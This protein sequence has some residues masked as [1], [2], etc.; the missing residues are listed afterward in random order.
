MY[1]HLFSDSTQSYNDK[2]FI[3]GSPKSDVVQ[4][5]GRILRQKKEKRLFHPLIIDINDNFSIFLNQSKK[6]LSFYNK[7]N[8][9][10][11]YYN[12]DGTSY[13]YIK[14]VKKSKKNTLNLEECLI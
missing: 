6:R 9:D 3:L 1:I 10:I 11:T 13:K 12:N 14:K 2:P 5:V 7:N 8:Y 4:S